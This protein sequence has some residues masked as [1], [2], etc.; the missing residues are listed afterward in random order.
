MMEASTIYD[1]EAN[2]AWCRLYA[3]QTVATMLTRNRI[4]EESVNGECKEVYAMRLHKQLRDVI[5]SG[6]HEQKIWSEIIKDLESRVIR[7]N[8]FPSCTQPRST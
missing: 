7:S 3:V 4:C 5:K 8:V 1:N 6:N 2:A